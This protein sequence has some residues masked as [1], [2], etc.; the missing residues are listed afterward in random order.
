MNL[1]TMR[2]RSYAVLMRINTKTA[3][4]LLS[5]LLPGCSTLSDFNRGCR[6]GIYEMN[7]N[8]KDLRINSI[9]NDESS[10]D[11]FCDELDANDRALKDPFSSKR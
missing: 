5:L 10:I 8:P 3:L 6:A 11:A 1:D 2:V 9:S 7:R 4:F